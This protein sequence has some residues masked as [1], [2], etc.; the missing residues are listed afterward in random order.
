MKASL[1]SLTPYLMA[2]ALA[3]CSGDK[4]EGKRSQPGGFFETPLLAQGPSI[5]NVSVAE[6]RALIDDDAAITVLDVRTPA[7][8]E[9]GHIKGAVNLDVMSDDFAERVAQLKKDDVYLIHCRSGRRSEA[10]L[11]SM[12]AAGFSTVAHMNEGVNG[13]TQAGLPLEP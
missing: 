4:E 9:E 5:R 11:E 6:A 3:A 12:R 8:F 13:W 1:T 2:L 7:E 10:A